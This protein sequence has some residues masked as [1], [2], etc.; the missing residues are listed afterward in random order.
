MSS[1]LAPVFFAIRINVE[2]SD[3]ASEFVLRDANVLG[4]LAVMTRRSDVQCPG[5]NTR[6]R[7][8]TVLN[9]LSHSSF[10]KGSPVQMIGR[11][12]KI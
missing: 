3:Q 6:R 9:G 12:Q 4:D 8:Q 11:F 5:R 1:L 7:L 2:N 10:I